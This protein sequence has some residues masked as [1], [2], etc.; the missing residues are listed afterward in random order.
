M[1]HK[2]KVTV[3]DKRD[4]DI[5]KKWVDDESMQCGARICLNQKTTFIKRAFKE[6]I[7]GTWSI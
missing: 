4:F 1:R 7:K 5:I 6:I 2:V 3:I